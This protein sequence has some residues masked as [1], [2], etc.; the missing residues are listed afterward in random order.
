MQ[1][2]VV[3]NVSCNVWMQGL[4]LFHMQT[5]FYGFILTTCR[6]NYL[7]LKLSLSLILTTYQ[8]VLLR[9]HKC[10]DRVLCNKGNISIFNLKAFLKEKRSKKASDYIQRKYWRY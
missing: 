2:S 1:R 3:L 4:I 5:K 8:R 10:A 9:T 7:H 6:C